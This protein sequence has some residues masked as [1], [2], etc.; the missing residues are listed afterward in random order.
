MDVCGCVFCAS[1]L[2]SICAERK[3]IDQALIGGSTRVYVCGDAARMAPDV[4]RALKAV[5]S[6]AGG[7]TEQKAS[8]YIDQLCAVGP[9]QR[10]FEDVWASG[11]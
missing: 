2:R 8:A 6:S 9:N 11:A 10:Y 5:C 4:K 7:L 1:A 3:R